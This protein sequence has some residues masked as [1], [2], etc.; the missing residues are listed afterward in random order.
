MMAV[1]MN[2]SL[3]ALSS[4]AF[5][6]C[7]QRVHVSQ[8][9]LGETHNIG[10]ISFAQNKI[11]M[12]SC[13]AIEADFLCPVGH[14]RSDL[15]VF[16]QCL[17]T[18]FQFPG[19]I[20]R[21]SSNIQ[22]FAAQKYCRFIFFALKVFYRLSKSIRNSCRAMRGDLNVSDD[23]IRT[24]NPDFKLCIE[25]NDG[26][27]KKI[28]GLFGIHYF[29]HSTDFENNHFSAVTAHDRS[30]HSGICV[31]RNACKHDAHSIAMRT[32][33]TRVKCEHESQFPY[34]HSEVSYV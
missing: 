25:V 11:L 9:C 32:F 19:L 16:S 26:A 33:L 4:T 12:S 34:R 2:S 21:P 14:I 6:K 8:K 22:C 18:L 30:P 7:W 15:A 23:W 27:R 29:G 31:A 24:I 3:V 20:H 1:E 13:I 17:Q 28:R 10:C 5:Y